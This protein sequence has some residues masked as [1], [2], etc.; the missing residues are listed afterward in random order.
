MDVLTDAD[1]IDPLWLKIEGYVK[2][3]REKLVRLLI[4][5]E[6]EEV[7]GRIRELELLVTP[8]ADTH[9]AHIHPRVSADEEGS[10]AH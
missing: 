8:P 4:N 7:R 1:R 9:T 5:K 10:W 3:R 2:A 6:S